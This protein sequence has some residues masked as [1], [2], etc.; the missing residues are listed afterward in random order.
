MINTMADALDGIRVRRTLVHMVALTL[1]P[2][3]VCAQDVAP[4]VR[5]EID[6][7]LAYLETSGCRFNRNGT[8]YPSVEAKAHI[9]SKFDYLLRHDLVDSAESFIERAASKSSTSGKPY[10]VQCQNQV[11]VESGAWFSNEL[12]RYRKLKG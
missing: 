5:T 1:L 12:K 6:H 7:L 3:A 4:T 8:W 2:I 10:M 9:A 11:P